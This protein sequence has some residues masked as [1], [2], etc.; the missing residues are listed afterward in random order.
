MEKN[1]Q[2]KVH[3]RKFLFWFI[4]IGG[5]FVGFFLFEKIYTNTLNSL[6]SKGFSILKNP[7]KRKRI[8]KNKA[9]EQYT[10]GTLIENTKTNVVHLRSK[11]LFTYYDKISESHIAEINFNNWQNTISDNKAHF[12]KGKS[13]LIFE[14]LSLRNL[15]TEI[16][17]QLIEESIQILSKAFSS[18]YYLYNIKNW[19]VYDLLLKYLALKGS[20]VNESWTSF[21]DLT[22][23]I[24]YTYIK[25][26]KK[27]KWIKSKNEF[28]KRINYAIN[29]RGKVIK[30]LQERI[31]V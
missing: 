16:T 26:P 17:P 11:I 1:N 21:S 14:H 27:N 30:K 22:K 10:N 7:D 12:I 13:G 23:N 5:T 20:N 24:E 2:I 9:L 25:I 19:R 3:R 18:E 29:N 28:E 15:S 4:P 8:Q 6:F 31:L